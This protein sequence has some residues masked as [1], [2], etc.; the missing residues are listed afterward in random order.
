ME[1]LQI[2]GVLPSIH[3]LQSN[4]QTVTCDKHEFEEGRPAEG[5]RWQEIE[6]RIL[7]VMGEASTPLLNL[8]GTQDLGGHG[9]V[10]LFEV[11][12]YSKRPP[13]ERGQGDC[14]YFC[15]A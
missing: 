14:E 12:V 11:R 2:R 1:S 7:L 13:R 3:L 15:N 9:R 5:A 10:V 6:C 8:T 4:A